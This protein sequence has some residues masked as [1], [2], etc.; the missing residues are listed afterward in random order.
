MLYCLTSDLYDDAVSLIGH[1]DFKYDLTS[2]EQ[3][4][5]IAPVGV[6]M[7]TTLPLVMLAARHLIDNQL[8]QNSVIVV[9][10]WVSSINYMNENL[11]TDLEFSHKETDAGWWEYR[12]IALGSSSMYYGKPIFTHHISVTGGVPRYIVGNGLHVKE[13]TFAEIAKSNSIKLGKVFPETPN[14]YAGNFAEYIIPYSLI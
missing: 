2:L 6:R 9:R 13:Y 4:V 8:W 10:N 1:E 7:C 3:L 14:M 11:C 12:F 5:D